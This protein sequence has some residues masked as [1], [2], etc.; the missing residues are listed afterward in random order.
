[1]F[2]MGSGMNGILMKRIAKRTNP[3]IFNQQDIL[4]AGL[5]GS[6]LPSIVAQYAEARSVDVERMRHR[7]GSNFPNL[8]GSKLCRDVDPVHPERSAINPHHLR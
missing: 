4:P 6:R 7:G 3:L 2:R 8:R 5:F 1:M